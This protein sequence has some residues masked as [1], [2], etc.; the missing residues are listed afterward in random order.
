MKAMPFF[1]GHGR[2]HADEEGDET[3]FKV[4]FPLRLHTRC[5]GTGG[6]FSI[7]S[8]KAGQ[9]NSPAC[10]DPVKGCSSSSSAGCT[11]MLEGVGSNRL[12]VQRFIHITSTKLLA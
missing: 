7:K 5:I 11:N 4:A 10:S 3:E 8:Y 12:Q 1:G 2:V 9:R 6:S